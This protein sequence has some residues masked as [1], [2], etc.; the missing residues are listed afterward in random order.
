M[1]LGEPVSNSMM[2][3]RYR[4]HATHNPTQTAPSFLLPIF[5]RPPYGNAL[6]AQRVSLNAETIL[7]FDVVSEALS[8]TRWHEDLVVRVNHPVIHAFE[9][10][11]HDVIVGTRSELKPKLTTLAVDRTLLDLPSLRL[12]VVEFCELDHLISEAAQEVYRFLHTVS[13]FSAVYWRDHTFL[14]ERARQNLQRYI[15]GHEIKFDDWS[16]LGGMTLAIKNDRPVLTCSAKLHNTL[17]PDIDWDAW[18]ES[19]KQGLRFHIG[20]FAKPSQLQ[21]VV[22]SDVS[23][24][25]EVPVSPITVRT[26]DRWLVAAFGQTAAFAAK[27]IQRRGIPAASIDTSRSLSAEAASIISATQRT[28]GQAGA[29]AP[30]L[31]VVISSVEESAS[32]VGSFLDAVPSDVRPYAIV[33]H[34][35]QDGV[36][37][38]KTDSALFRS[39]RFEGMIVIPDNDFPIGE[40]STKT[41]RGTLLVSLIGALGRLLQD[42]N[43][44]PKGRSIYSIAWTRFGLRGYQGALARGIAAAANP[45]ISIGHASRALVSLS[46]V[47]RPDSDFAIDVARQLNAILFEEDAAATHE[48]DSLAVESKWIQRRFLPGGN[49]PATVELFLTGI[50]DEPRSPEGGLAE[51]AKIILAAAGYEVKGDRNGDLFISTNGEEPLLIAAG[52]MTRSTRPAVYVQL[53]PDKRSQKGALAQYDAWKSALPLMVGDLYFLTNVR[54]P[55]WTATLLAHLAQPKRLWRDA[56]KEF[57]QQSL[58]RELHRNANF[59]DLWL[60][61]LPES[62]NVMTTVAIE[63][64]ERLAGRQ[65]KIDGIMT[66]K[67]NVFAASSGERSERS[68]SAKFEVKLG[69]DEFSVA[70]FEVLL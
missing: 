44:L 32:A 47:G 35:T 45:W 59:R 37:S 28:R 42:H 1:A 43:V 27:E 9:M 34:R 54:D 55:K 69:P 23:P 61:D 60:Q 24:S 38:D 29:R 41:S 36:P 65:A 22:G 63:G 40:A 56:F 67:F 11:S 46:S 51:T 15:S 14:A 25:R 8:S 7:G 20:A 57:V 19:V 3:E 49:I 18:V 53:M 39:D 58:Q 12:D 66:A 52:Y 26:S 64:A 13:S 6:Y 68:K 4:L 33:L 70:K 17:K 21:F 30:I 31:L 50:T 10:P 16:Q 5:S 62:A 48:K 2:L